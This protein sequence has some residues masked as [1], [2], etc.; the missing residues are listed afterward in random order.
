MKVY[1]LPQKQ[2]MKISMLIVVQQTVNN[3][4]PCL[5]A[6]HHPIKEN[7]GIDESQLKTSQ[8]IWAELSPLIA[9]DIVA[10]TAVTAILK[11]PKNR[12]W[13]STLEQA[14]IR[15]LGENP[16]LTTSLAGILNIS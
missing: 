1:L 8:A 5:A 10:R 7:Q 4:I 13:Y 6:L 11:N 15:I 3:L 9:N 2:C 14:L 16:A 12:V